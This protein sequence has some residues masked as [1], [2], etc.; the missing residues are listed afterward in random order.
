LSNIE[1][2]FEMPKLDFA[3]VG[4]RRAIIAQDFSGRQTQPED[5]ISN[6]CEGCA[7]T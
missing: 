4:L 5:S 2:K 1:K 6:R 7:Q 3:E